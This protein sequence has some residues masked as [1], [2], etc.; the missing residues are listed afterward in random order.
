MLVVGEEEFR[1]YDVETLTDHIYEFSL[2][3]VRSLA[4][5]KSAGRK[6]K[7]EGRS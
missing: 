3:A 7:G 5:P 6:G 1:S 4:E 2:A